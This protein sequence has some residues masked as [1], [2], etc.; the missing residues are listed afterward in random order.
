MISLLKKIWIHIERHRRTQCFIFI[1][2][3][4]LSS[5]AEIIS[6]AT[7][8]PFLGILSGKDKFFESEIFK[9][10]NNYIH[11]NLDDDF[12][13]NFTLIFIFA[14]LL[15]GLLRI[16]LVYFQTKLSYSIG[17][18]LSIKVYKNTINQP[19]KKQLQYN[20]SEIISTILNKTNII[21]GSIIIPVLSIISAFIISFSIVTALMIIDPILVGSI[22]L[23]IALIYFSLTLLCNKIIYFY[24][25]DISIKLNKIVK[26]VQESFG[27]IRDV[28]INNSQH[29]FIDIY[30]KDQ[31]QLKKHIQT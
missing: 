8:I 2:L 22:I 31:T 20:S 30:R 4:I 14:A 19:Y 9:I 11:I 21:V 28:I 25:Q 12:F 6:L 24:G 5:F 15:S 16:L 13:L 26:I 1:F 17:A 3:N 27:G 7:V 23:F 10:I 18:D 29:Q